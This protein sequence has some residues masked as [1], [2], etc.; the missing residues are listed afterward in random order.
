MKTSAGGFRVAVIGASSLLGKELLAVLGERHFPI[1]RLITPGTLDDSEPDLPVLDLSGGLEAAVAEADVGESDLDYVFLAAPVR[2]A[3]K[4]G[5]AGAPDDASFLQ[6]TQRLAAATRCKVIDLSDCLA[7]ENGGGLSAPLLGRSNAADARPDESATARFLVSAHAATLVIG[8]IILRLGERFPMKSVVAQVY[9]PVSEMGAQ[10]IE[11]LQKQTMNLLSFQK[12]PQNVFGAQ[13]AFNLLP[14]LG[15]NRGKSVKGSGGQLQSEL[16]VLLG[17][18]LPLPALRVLY[19]PVFHSLSC[20]LYADFDPPAALEALTENLAGKPICMRKDSDA[21]PTQADAT[22]SSDIVVD[23]LTPDGIQPGGV[24]IWAAAD[25]LRLAA[26]NAVEIAEM[27]NE[28]MRTRT[29]EDATGDK[30]TPSRP[31]Q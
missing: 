17:P 2:P 24:W 25:N 18:G 8:A 3:A 1:S 23:V 10:A 14:R 6:S 31:P 30:A 19:A 28:Q 5:T 27:L 16:A 20:L 21:P 7:G 4:K 29:R 22:G 15:R 11:E 12:I 26:V 13:L 9:Q